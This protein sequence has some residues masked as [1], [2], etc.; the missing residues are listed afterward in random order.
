MM[1][2]KHIRARAE[3]RKGAKVLA[4]LIPEAASNRALAKVADDR[5]LA[6]MTRRVF[7][8]GFVWRTCCGRST[9][10]RVGRTGD[11]HE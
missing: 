2:F 9:G 11:G 7:S 8:A 3:K 5:I 10:P 1:Q 6:E 4:S